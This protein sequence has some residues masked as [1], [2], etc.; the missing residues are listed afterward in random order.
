MH[1]GIATR[2]GQDEVLELLIDPHICE[3]L[4]AQPVDFCSKMFPHLAP[5]ILADT[6]CS[7]TPLDVDMLIN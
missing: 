1:I 2:S 3:P 4:S 7:D 5:L 6:H